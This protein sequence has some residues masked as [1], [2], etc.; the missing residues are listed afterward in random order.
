MFHVLFGC[1]FLL[2]AFLITPL[3]YRNEGLSVTHT[4]YNSSTHVSLYVWTW[5]SINV[6][7]QRL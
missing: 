3:V 4:T 7:L 2:Q 5:V 6:F 1:G